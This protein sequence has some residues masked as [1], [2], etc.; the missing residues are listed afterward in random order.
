MKKL[1]NEGKIWDFF[2]LLTQSLEFILNRLPLCD[3]LIFLLI[4]FSYLHPMLG[5]DL[6]SIVLFM[7]E[8]VHLFLRF[9]VI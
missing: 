1:Q 3:I 4:C 8:I 5:E 2:P 6:L 7:I 9:V